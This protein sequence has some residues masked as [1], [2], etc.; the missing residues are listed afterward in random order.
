MRIMEQELMERLVSVIIREQHKSNGHKGDHGWYERRAWF[1]NLP[2][3]RRHEE[4]AAAGGHA[5]LDP[6]NTVKSHWR[7][8]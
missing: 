3:G 8:S 6:D 7:N 4:D 2:R 1:I 5:A